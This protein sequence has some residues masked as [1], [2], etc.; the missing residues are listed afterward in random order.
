ME[1][2]QVLTVQGL[3]KSF[4]GV[5]VADGIDLELGA[6]AR[7]GLIGPNG[8]GKTTFVN[9]LTGTLAATSGTIRLDGQIINRLPPEQRVRIG[10]VR[11]HQINTL[12]N[13]MSARDNVALAVAQRNNMT[14]FPLAFRHQWRQCQE[15]ADSCLDGVFLGDVRSRR[16]AELAYGQQ[17]LLEIAIALALHPKVLLLD[18]PAAGVPAA[19]VHIIYD[20]LERLPRN[21]ATIIIEHDMDLIYR[22]AQQ[23]ILLVR[24]SILVRGTAAEISS[25]PLVRSVYLGKGAS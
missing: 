11:T 23:I 18:E 14:W 1:S 15:E 7:F 20:A 6:G 16:V 17:R 25:D 2:P 21:V 3:R 10:L 9:L 5:I 12:L 19:E 13:D 24:G 8:A 4:G 22:F